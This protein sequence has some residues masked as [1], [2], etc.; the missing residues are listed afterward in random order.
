VPIRLEHKMSIAEVKAELEPEGFRIDKVLDV[1]PWQHIFIC[2][3][4]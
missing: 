3:K 4:K 2:K 1:L